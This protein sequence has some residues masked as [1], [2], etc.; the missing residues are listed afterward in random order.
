[1]PQPVRILVLDD[2]EALRRMLEEI[3]EMK[4]YPCKTASTAEEALTLWSQEM[5]GSAPFRLALADLS[6]GD[7]PGGMAFARQV[8]K[9]DPKAL[10]I[11]CTGDSS[12]PIVSDPS[13]YGFDGTLTKPFLFGA[14]LE[15]LTRIIG[16][17]ANEVSTI[18]LP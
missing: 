5:S 1:M 6:L 3:L 9:L 10:L 7:G 13:R 16:G 4:G 17:T 18:R 8:R 15:T 2:E 11:A 14:L 12:D